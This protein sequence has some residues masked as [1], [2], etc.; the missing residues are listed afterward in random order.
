MINKLRN[1]FLKEICEKLLTV[2][3]DGIPN[4]AD[5]SSKISISLAKGI[6]DEIGVKLSPKVKA[7]GQSSGKSFEV[8][9]KD[10]LKNAFQ[11]LS[12]LRGGKYEFFLGK[13]IH[14]FE[15]YEHLAY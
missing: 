1:E 15:Q 5:R 9:T 2:D 4:N 6:V 7:P 12:H 14:S 13:S 11:Y 8:I 10:Y 3:S